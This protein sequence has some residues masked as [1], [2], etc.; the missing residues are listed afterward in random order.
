M[1]TWQQQIPGRFAGM[2]APVAMHPKDEKR[3][4]E[5]LEEMQTQGVKSSEAV[6]KIR[7]YLIKQKATPEEMTKQMLRS[8]EKLRPWLDG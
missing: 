2:T 1:R 4:M 5:M 8:E 6:A 3:A 7:A